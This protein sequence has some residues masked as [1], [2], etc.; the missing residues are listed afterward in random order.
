M[1]YPL[2]SGERRHPFRRFQPIEKR[3]SARPTDRMT[4]SGRDLGQRN[5][6]E[7]ALIHTRMGQG[8][9]EV[10]VGWRAVVAQF[11]RDDLPLVV[12]Q[13]E[14]ERAGCPAHMAGPSELGFE[15][16]KACQKVCGGQRRGHNGDGI[17]IR[18]LHIMGDGGCAIEG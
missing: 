2:N 5:Q 4:P 15:T 10:E 3:R 12:Q 17:Y 1:S 8:E 9:R 11:R 7:S 18:R 13:V 6:H 16:V 14:V